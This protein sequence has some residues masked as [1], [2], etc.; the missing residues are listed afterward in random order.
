MSP[1]NVLVGD[2]GI[3][4]HP[5]HLRCL[6]AQRAAAPLARNPRGTRLC[7]VQH[8]ASRWMHHAARMER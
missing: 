1:E 8:S 7:A 4:S 2:S 3:A 5:T 6:Q